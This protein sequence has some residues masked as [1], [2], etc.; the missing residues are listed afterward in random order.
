MGC[1]SDPYTTK[2]EH[3]SLLRAPCIILPLWS[4]V[5]CWFLSQ[6]QMIPTYGHHHNCSHFLSTYH[7]PDTA[8]S[9]LH[10][11]LAHEMPASVLDMGVIPCYHG[12]SEKWRDLP[13]ATQLLSA[14]EPGLESR[15]VWPQSTCQPSISS[16][17]RC[18]L[19]ALQLTSQPLKRLRGLRNQPL[20][21]PCP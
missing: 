11:S 4:C 3:T 20:A 6:R 21:S 5:S 10:R 7:L 12:G 13:K 14:R 2:S 18:D 1:C 15:S 17:N 9:P 19:H 16:L 8:P